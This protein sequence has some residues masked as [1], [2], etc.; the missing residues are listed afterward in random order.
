[1]IF[2]EFFLLVL[3]YYKRSDFFYKLSN[4]IS[5][6]QQYDEQIVGLE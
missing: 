5:N 6:P 2:T 4:F 1:M 3:I